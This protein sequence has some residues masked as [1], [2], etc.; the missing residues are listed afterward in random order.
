[1]TQF[2]FRL[3]RQPFLHGKFVD[4]HRKDRHELTSATDGSQVMTDLQWAALEDVELAVDSAEKGLKD[5]QALSPEK[6]RSYLLRY[7]DLIESHAE[8]LAYLEVI[9]TGKPMVLASGYEAPQLANILRYKLSGESYPLGDGLVK[10]VVHEPLGVCAAIT[11][12]N[13]PMIL[14]ALKVA[15][16]LASGNVMIIK[17]SEFNP[18]SSLRLA[19]LATEAGLPNGAIN[20]LI[21]GADVGNA[22]ATHKRIRKISFTGSVATGKKVQIAAT[23]SNLKRVTLEL[24]GKSPVVIFRDANLNNAARAASNF[25]AFNGQGCILGTRILVQ[26]EISDPFL[27]ALK[28]LIQ[29][30]AK[31]LGSDPMELSTLSCPLFHLQQHTRVAEFLDLGKQEAEVLVGGSVCQRPGLYVEPTVFVNPKPGARILHEEIFGP[32][33]VVQT[34]KTESEAIEMA[35]NTEYGLGAFIHTNDISRAL[36]VASKIQSGTV[37]INTSENMSPQMP[38]GGNK[39]SGLGRENARYA[40]MAY[41]EPKSIFIRI[42]ESIE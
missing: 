33:A 26:E 38:F 17:G 15:P 18:L 40:L 19:E 42:L 11:A 16:A 4:S 30:H 32:V 8:E 25:L 5:W 9:V 22:L 36:R 21:G 37:A 35:N 3:P 10:M 20:V 39:I 27:Q 1:M 12:F 31:T 6:R 24:G 2:K 29:E 34:F 7:A 13:S 28:Q 23:E 14:F 41:T